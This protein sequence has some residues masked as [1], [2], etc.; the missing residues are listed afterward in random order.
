[1]L[2][3]VFLYFRL[4]VGRQRNAFTD[5]QPTTEMDSPKGS[6]PAT[7]TTAPM[8]PNMEKGDSRVQSTVHVEAMVR[9]KPEMLMF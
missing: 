8:T 9:E 1:V 6:S 5:A 4:C 3:W 2:P 7:T